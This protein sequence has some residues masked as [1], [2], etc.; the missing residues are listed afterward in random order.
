MWVLPT[1]DSRIM[2]WPDAKGAGYFDLIAELLKRFPE[3]F[4]ERNQ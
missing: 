1:E 4:L 2:L 3:V